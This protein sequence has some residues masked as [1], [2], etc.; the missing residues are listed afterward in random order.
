M[1]KKIQDVVDACLQ[2][3]NV[4]AIILIVGLAESVALEDV[5]LR[6]R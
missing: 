2:R 5:N 1:K 3:K 6:A 4:C